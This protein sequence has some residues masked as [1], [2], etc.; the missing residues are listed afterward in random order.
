MIIGLTGPIAAGKDQVAQ[1][2]AQLGGVIIN[3]DDLAHTLYTPQTPLWRELIKVFGSKILQRGGEINR[4]KLGEIVFTDKNKLH[5]LNSLVHPFLKERVIEMVGKNNV[6]SSNL[7]II[8][9]AVLKEIGLVE[10]VDEVWVVLALQE[11]RLKRLMRKG[12]S[13]PE[14][15]VRIKAQSFIKDYLE[16]ADVV[17]KNEGSLKEL[18]KKVLD[19]L[20]NRGEL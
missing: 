10:L 6:D 13:K 5:L 14:A 18:K 2:L 9:A 17:I 11:I 20:N 7:I 3:A 12:L 8:N 19:L 4:K 1:I 15:Q 16:M